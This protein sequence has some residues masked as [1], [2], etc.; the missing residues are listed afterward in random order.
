M[1][2]VL[3][4]TSRA[5]KKPSKPYWK[6]SPLLV[7]KPGSQIAIAMDAAS[8]EMW[9]EK[10]NG[11]KFYKST[12]KVISSDEMVAYWANWVKQ[13]PIISIEDGMAE[14][15]WE[16]WKNLTQAI[17][18]KCQLVGDDLFVTNVKRLTTRY[19]SK[20]SPTVSLIKVN[21]IGYSN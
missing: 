14:D 9:D 10:T 19:R 21:Q 1:K 3:L 16:G 4:R 17:G 13:Y 15:D 18:S 8:T 2:V 5:M 11:Y 12:N 20:V 7:T 6:L